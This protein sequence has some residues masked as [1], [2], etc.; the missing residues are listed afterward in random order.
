LLSIILNFG[1]ISGEYKERCHPLEVI[2]TS[3]ANGTW[4][5]VS[6][7]FNGSLIHTKSGCLKQRDDLLKRFGLEMHDSSYKASRFLS[8][9]CLSS[10]MVLWAPRKIDIAL[11]RGSV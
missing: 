6:S 7:A 9:F 2:Y 11:D 8:N 4:R 5:L 10:A 3:F 1:L